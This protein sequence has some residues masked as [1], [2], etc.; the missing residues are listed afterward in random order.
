MKGQTLHSAFRLP[1]NQKTLSPLS[2]SMS[3]TMATKLGH[4]KVL[5]IDEISM[6][7]KHTLQM[8]NERLQHIMGNKQ[9][10]GG[11]SV[12]AVGDF[13]QL[14]PLFAQP[15][16]SSSNNVYEDI[17][18]KPLW[19]KFKVFQLTQIMRQS[20]KSLQK[21]LNNL[22]KGKLQSIDIDLFKSRTLTSL[23]RN[24]RIE[25]AVHLF[26][27]NIHVDNF[28]QKEWRKLKGKLHMSKA[29]DVIRGTGTR[30]A[31]K[32]L[33]YT[34][35]NST[36]Q[37]T[38]GIPSEIALKINA[39]YMVSYNVDT[40]DGIC[41]GATGTLKKI[42]FGKNTDGLKKPLRLWMEF[43]DITCEP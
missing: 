1:P 42:D 7:G 39:K 12:I 21:A 23:P 9:D 11:V 29:S 35:K 19:H 4:L 26:A 20:D 31:R 30:L 37:D 25:N 16:Y 27:K 28:N 43:D 22:A 38:M 18:S 3:N 15:L 14:K 10:F 34:L 33:L 17:F 2:A 32:Q 8:V 6:V 13:F 5:I 41:N 24:K 36:H 40:E